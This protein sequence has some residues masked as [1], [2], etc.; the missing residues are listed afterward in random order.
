MGR[1]QITNEW[2]RLTNLGAIA[3]G[4]PMSLPAARLVKNPHYYTG[5]P[6]KYGHLVVRRTYIAGCPRCNQLR[7]RGHHASGLEPRMVK[8]FHQ[9]MNLHNRKLGFRAAEGSVIE[10][11]YHE[12][13]THR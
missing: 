4:L 11:R 13:T 10:E 7:S 6:C 5:I 2:E 8:V 9:Q 3:L 1:H 12:R